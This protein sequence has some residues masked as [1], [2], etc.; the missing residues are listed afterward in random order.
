MR[1]VAERLNQFHHKMESTPWYRLI[2]GNFSIVKIPSLPSFHRYG[3]VREHNKPPLLSLQCCS[4]FT[5]NLVVDN[6]FVSSATVIIFVFTVKHFCPR[7]RSDRFKVTSGQ[8]AL[9]K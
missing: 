5:N 7:A 1:S 9:I 3:S 8:R 2:G 4:H 6:T